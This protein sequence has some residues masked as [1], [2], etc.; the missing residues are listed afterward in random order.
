ME[1]WKYIQG[2]E[3]KYMISNT[4]RV[5]SI[6]RNGTIKTERILKLQEDK[7]GYL[8]VR[9]HLGHMNKRKAFKVHRLVANVFLNNPLNLPQVNHIDENKKNNDVNN[10]EWCDN[11][12]NMNYGTRGK[13]YSKMIRDE[14]GKFVCVEY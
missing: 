3:G 8:Y 5:K 1:V 14:K 7:D 13:L 10:L 4:G 12:Y 11:K 9:L 2:F 6:P